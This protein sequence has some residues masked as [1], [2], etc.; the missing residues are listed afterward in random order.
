M[1]LTKYKEGSVQELWKIS[2]PLML[3]SFS[4]MFMLFIDRLLL[5]QYSLDAVN[6]AVNATTIGWACLFGWIVLCGISEVFVAQY[7]GANQFDKLGSP[8]WQ[9]IW[10][11]LLS[12]FWFIPLGIWGGNLIFSY[13]DFSH[14]E[15]EYFK[16][17]MFFSPSYPLYAAL[18]GFFIGRG[19]TSLVT[20]LTIVANIVNAFLDAILIFGIPGW[21]PSLGVKGAAIATSATG[22]LQAIILFVVFL[23]PVY[24]NKFATLNYRFNKPLFMQCLKIGLPNAIFCVVETIGFAVFYALMTRLGKEYITIAGINQSIMILFFFFAEGLSKGAT[25]IVGNLIGANKNHF[26]S[27]VITSGIKLH[28]IFFLIIS[29]FFYFFADFLLNL[30]IPQNDSYTFFQYR[31]AL[32]TSLVFMS[33]FLL[34]DGIRLLLAGVLTAAGDTVF[35]FLAGSGTVWLLFVLPTYFFIYIPKAPVEMASVLCFIYGILSCFIYLYRFLSDSWK[36]KQII[37]E[38]VS[39]SEK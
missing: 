26:V 17:M 10:L 3:S 13:S 32:F 27:K 7:N 36:K 25:T 20:G 4:V 30:F 14:Y 1:Q 31:N 12:F 39:V 21:I 16:W 34:F 15:K 9:M 6:A 29:S 38:K 19:K 35:L 28:F 2:F 37:L 24:Q 18:C 33:A 23:K 11:S 8:V 22:M 5:A